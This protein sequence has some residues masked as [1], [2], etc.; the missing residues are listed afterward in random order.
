MISINFRTIIVH[1]CLFLAFFLPIYSW[2]QYILVLL[3][4]I[5][6]VF[7]SDKKLNIGWNYIVVLCLC[8]SVLFNSYWLSP[9]YYKSFLKTVNLCIL[10]ALFPFYKYKDISIRPWF[11]VLMMCI[12]LYTQLVW[13]FGIK[14]MMS[15]FDMI[16][17]QTITYGQS[18]VGFSFNLGGR[19]GG[20][21]HNP[22]DCARNIIILCAIYLVLN[23]LNSSKRLDIF[24]LLI[25]SLSVFLTGSRTGIIMLMATI[26]IYIL[27]MENVNRQKKLIVLSFV[28]FLL[29]L[30]SVFIIGEN[31]RIKNTV[32]NPGK[33]D[34]FR[35]FIEL[36]EKVLTHPIKSLFGYFYMERVVLWKKGLTGGFDADLTNLIYA[37]GFSTIIS[38]FF[39]I[40]SLY[41]KTGRRFFY[42]IPPHFILFST[43]L[44]TSFYSAIMILMLYSILYLESV[45]ENEDRDKY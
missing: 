15:F 43:G 3:P 41:K 1:T 11:V 18:G 39:F 16:Y 8:F 23:K 32:F 26:V 37:Y 5:L 10:F 19:Y 25:M 42:C 12:V 36:I 30:V 14:P 6:Y 29:I 24:V 27:N 34:R 7:V 33:S 38:Y 22:N 21:F 31:N 9:I 2:S 40:Y 35:F 13:L 45:N 44:L 4:V 20:I 28:I 17:P